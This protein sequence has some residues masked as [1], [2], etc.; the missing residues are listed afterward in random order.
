M[1]SLLRAVIAVALFQ[2]AHSAEL[3]N[4]KIAWTND[5]AK[6]SLTKSDDPLTTIYALPSGGQPKG[7]QIL[8]QQLTRNPKDQP[9]V[10]VYL[11]NSFYGINIAMQRGFDMV[12]QKCSC[13]WVD[14]QML[15]NHKLPSSSQYR[16][17]FQSSNGEVN[18][19]SGVFAMSWSTQLVEGERKEY[20]AP[21]ATVYDFDVTAN[22]LNTL[23][24]NNNKNDNKNTGAPAVQ[25]PQSYDGDNK[26]AVTPIPSSSVSVLGS[27]YA[28][29]IVLMLTALILN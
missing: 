24:N 21:P 26:A 25:A 19:Q 3:S 9:L 8:Y 23:N 22:D 13:Y 6:T 14:A 27:G 12:S 5:P 1:N 11:V 17:V 18:L 4:G 2:V 7:A 29:S 15:I 10:T 20:T 28:L 16:V